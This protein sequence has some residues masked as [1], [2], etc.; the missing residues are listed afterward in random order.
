MPPVGTE[1]GQWSAKVAAESDAGNARITA[2]T[3]FKHCWLSDEFRVGDGC[4]GASSGQLAG[5]AS[6]LALPTIL[7]RRQAVSRSMPTNARNASILALP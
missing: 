5:N 7:V 2:L 3:E 4:R 6:F 1:R